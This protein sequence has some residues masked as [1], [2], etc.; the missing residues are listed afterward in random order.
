M[1]LDVA[2]N[3][4]DRQD[5]AA[6]YPQRAILRSTPAEPDNRTRQSA[7]NKESNARTDSWPVDSTSTP[8]EDKHGR[9]RHSSLLAG[10]MAA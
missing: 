3:L 5:R 4:A 2:L 1:G 10:Q 8:N 9:W 6:A 7:P